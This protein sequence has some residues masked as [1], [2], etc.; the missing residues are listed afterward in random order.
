MIGV[1]VNSALMKKLFVIR[2]VVMTPSSMVKP[3]KLR[4]AEVSNPVTGTIDEPE[5]ETW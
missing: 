5:E 3:S 4:E 1:V 2:L